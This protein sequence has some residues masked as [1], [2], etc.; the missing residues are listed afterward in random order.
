MTLLSLILVVESGDADA[1]L[2]H[3]DR[4]TRE[5]EFAEATSTNLLRLHSVYM[6]KHFVERIREIF[7]NPLFLLVPGAGIEPARLQ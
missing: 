6:Q 1:R 7:I 4:T 5:S 2:Q 3:I